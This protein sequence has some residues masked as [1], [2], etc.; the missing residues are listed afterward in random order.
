MNTPQRTGVAVVTDDKFVGI[1][2]VKPVCWLFRAQDFNKTYQRKRTSSARWAKA[3][4]KTAHG[5]PVV[6]TKSKLAA[7]PVEAQPFADS[8]IENTCRPNDDKIR[9][10]VRWGVCTLIYSQTG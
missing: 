2:Q 3:D 5:W 6:E 1:N 10:V 7:Q 9:K 4:S 8:S